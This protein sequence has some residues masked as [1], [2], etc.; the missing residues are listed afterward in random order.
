MPWSDPDK[1]QLSKYQT[2]AIYR[3]IASSEVPVANFELIWRTDPGIQ[4]LVRPRIFAVIRH[5]TTKSLFG[6]KQIRKRSFWVRYRVGADD[7]T[8]G[9]L[10][11]RAW[12]SFNPNHKWDTVLAEVQKWT[13]RVGDLAKE[14]EQYEST[15]DLWE[16]LNRSKNF[17]TSQSEQSTGNAP[18]TDAEQ[19][20]IS[21]QINQIKDYIKAAHELT[22]EQISHVEIRLDQVEQ[23]SRRLGRK[24]WLMTFNGAVFSLI[25]TDLI[26]PQTAQH[27]IMMTIHGLS[28]LFGIGGPPPHFLSGG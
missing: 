23:A 12:K 19:A 9:K 27:V 2:N 25:L 26:T 11:P 14:I 22:S 16:E 18:F 3:M 5:S 15:S 10:F 7:D 8:E 6:I 24:D 28:H 13:G 20:D 17:F 4:F 1:Y 21:A